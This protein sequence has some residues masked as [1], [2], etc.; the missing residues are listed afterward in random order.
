MMFIKDHI[1]ICPGGEFLLGVIF[2]T[3]ILQ[4][5]RIYAMRLPV[6]S[7][8][9]VVTFKS[10]NQGIEPTAGEHDSTNLFEK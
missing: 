2:I 10:S 1:A 5:L 7:N 3:F 8:Q 9:L 6:T 4:D